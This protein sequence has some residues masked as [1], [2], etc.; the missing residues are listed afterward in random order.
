MVDL[1][2]YFKESVIAAKDTPVVY[3]VSIQS[4]A[5]ISWCTMAEVLVK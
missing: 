3:H 4:F 5:G 2:V 1:T